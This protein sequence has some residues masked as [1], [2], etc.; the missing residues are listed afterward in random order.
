MFIVGLTGGIA[1][2]KSTVAR[3][4]VDHGAVHV[5]ADAISREVVEPS[6]SGLEAVAAEFGAGVLADDGSLDRAALGAIVFADPDAR[7]RLEAIVHPRVH[8][9]TA[10]LIAA[11]E[12][13]DPAAVVVYDV[14][15]LV[16]ARRELQFD[17]IVVCEAPVETRISRLLTHRGMPRAEAERRISAQASDDERR[18]VADVVIDTSGSL[19]HTLD[20]VDALWADLSARAQDRARVS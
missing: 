19:Q 2:G 3:R 9:R 6:T 16:E 17:L 10:E 4:L 8:A 11:A 13:A 14:P 5:D 15:L 20:Q 18:A 12:A 7:G 1:S